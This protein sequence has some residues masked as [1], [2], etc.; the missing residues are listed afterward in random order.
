MTRTN[1]RTPLRAGIA[2]ACLLAAALPAGCRPASQPQA[3]LKV[4]A[5]ASLKEAFEDVAAAFTAARPGA[6]VTFNFAGSQQ[7]VQQIGQGAP[8]DVFASANT[9]QMAAAIASGRIVSGTQQVFARNRLV[10]VLPADNPAGV[11]QLQDLARPGLRLVL[12][13]REVPA[14]QYA[15]E[16]LDK[17]SADPAFGAAYREDVLKNARSFEENVRAVLAKVSLGEA[18]AG[19]VYVSDAAAADVAQLAIPDAL[20]VIAEYPIAALRDAADP[21]QAAAF[22]ALVLSADGQ[23]ILAEHGFIPAAGR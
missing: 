8:A 18:D 20:N 9:R 4:F 7:L 3:D 10:V 11:R 22:V 21:A 14:G 2:L 19:I 1:R 17:A 15:L 16:F 23:R 12:A 13:A 5:A 6:R